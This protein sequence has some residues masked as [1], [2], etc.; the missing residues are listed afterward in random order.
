MTIQSRLEQFISSFSVRRNVQVPGI[1]AESGP[2]S[3][4]CIFP[5]PTLI[6]QCSGH[7]EVATARDPLPRVSEFAATDHHRRDWPGRNR[8]EVVRRAG[9]DST[10]QLGVE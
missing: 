1:S 2:V 8:L 5:W 4:A 7:T 9:G 10:D 3:A 6:L